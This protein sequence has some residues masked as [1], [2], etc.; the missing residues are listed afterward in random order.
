MTVSDTGCGIPAD[1]QARIF[2][3]FYRADKARTPP[4]PRT[5]TAWRRMAAARDLDSPSHSGSPKRTTD[6]SRSHAQ[7][8]A[9][10]AGAM[11]LFGTE[12]GNGK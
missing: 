4:L 11:E 9:A 12:F 3:R 6:S 1:A 2:E 7:T 10:T 5:V 8:R